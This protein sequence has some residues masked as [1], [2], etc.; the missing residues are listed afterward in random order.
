[1]RQQWV[2]R[3]KEDGLER[4]FIFGSINN[5]VIALI[6]FRLKFPYAF[7]EGKVPE[8][9]ELEEVIYGKPACTPLVY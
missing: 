9:F 5:R 4:E 2:A 7:F 8:H 3:W 6:D 1:M